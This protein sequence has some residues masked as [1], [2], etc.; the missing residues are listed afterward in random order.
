MQSWQIFHFVRKNLGAS[1]LYAIFGKKNARKVDYWAQNP[2]CT[3]KPEN[4]YDPISGVKHLVETLDDYGHTDVARAAISFITADTSL[5]ETDNDPEVAE[6]QDTIEREILLDYR[7]VSK[8]EQ[9]IEAGEDVADVEQ[10]KTE[11]IE[12][13]IRTVALYRKMVRR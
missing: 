3:N 11:A 7:A 1:A 2:R 5:A 10:L 12:E 6:L 4:A 9:A 8:M 13:I